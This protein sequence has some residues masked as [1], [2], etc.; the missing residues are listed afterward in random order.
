MSFLVI[1]RHGESQANR[2]NIF[3]GWNDVDLTAHGVEQA[4][5]AAQ[6]ILSTGI[7]F[8][9]AHT[10]L[11]KRAIAT[12][13][14]ICDSIDQSYVP[15]HKTWRLNERHYGALRGLNKD[16]VRKQYGAEQ[17]AIWRR[18]YAAI[19]PLLEQHDHDR[20]Y[21][22]LGVQVPLSESLKMTW[23]RI[24]PYWTH[25]IAPQL[26]DGQN[27]LIVA[28]GST[29][30]ALIKYLDDIPDD[31]ID[32]VE[33]GNGQPIVYEF[34]QQLNIISKQALIKK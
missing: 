25:H 30:R 19:P 23:E 8:S 7:Q 9:D 34:D 14:L 12:A 21:N 27:Q 4:R 5:E 32:H 18:S 28:H 33:V 13:N 11:L 24:L 3:T 15:I 31:Q 22:R 16:V 6:L 20:R 1:T 29:L 2:D 10:S 17:V 26:L